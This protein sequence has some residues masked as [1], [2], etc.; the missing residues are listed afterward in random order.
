MKFQ[1]SMIAFDCI[2]SRHFTHAESNV[3]KHFD[4]IHI[5][6][7]VYS[8]YAGFHEFI[9]FDLERDNIKFTNQ[10]YAQIFEEAYRESANE[11][12]EPARYFTSHADENI[13]KLAIEM[14]SDKYQLSKIH[15]KIL[16]EEEDDE[17]S[18]LLEENSLEILIPRVTTELKNAYVMQQISLVMKKIKEAQNDDDFETTLKLLEEKK[19]LE[20]IK[21]LLAKML[22]EQ[23]IIRY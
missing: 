20:E 7:C 15:A 6:W 14:V 12:F 16:G 18:T 4:T 13:S 17:K 1:F 8:F 23:V 11:D 5:A 22:G 2:V 19:K 21:K 3:S 9:H 10:L